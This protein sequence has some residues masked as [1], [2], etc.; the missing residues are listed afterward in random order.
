MPNSKLYN[1]LRQLHCETGPAI[2]LPN[3][4]VEWWLNNYAYS[5]DQWCMLLNKTDEERMLLKLRY[6]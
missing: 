4:D 6:A 3:G 1:H 5:F 2:I